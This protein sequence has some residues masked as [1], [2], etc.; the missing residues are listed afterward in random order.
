MYLIDL[1][2]IT[3]LCTRTIGLVESNKQIASPPTLRLLSKALDVPISFLGCF[4]QLPEATLGNRI[5]K[6]RLYHG[7][8]KREFAKLL[9]VDVKSLYNW[10]NDRVVPADP[11]LNLLANYIDI[12]MKE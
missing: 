12:I 6:A 11:H 9:D 10:E 4:E 5:T 8:S 1:A 3:G 7:Y 2:S